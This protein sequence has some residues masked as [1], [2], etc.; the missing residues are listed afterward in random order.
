MHSPALPTAEQLAPRFPSARQAKKK[1]RQ[2]RF[3]AAGGDKPADDKPAGAAPVAAL[4]EEEKK[5][6]DERA[7]RCVGCFCWH[8]LDGRGQLR[9][10]RCWVPRFLVLAKEAAAAGVRMRCIWAWRS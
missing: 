6:R 3:G 8:V 7:K 10:C 9:W 1:A 2:E 4:S 5:K